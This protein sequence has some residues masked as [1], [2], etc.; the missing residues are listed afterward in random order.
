M[1]MSTALYPGSF[2]PVHNG[3]LG[4]LESIAP[5]FDGVI[6][7]VGHNP[8]KPSGLFTPDERKALLESVTSHLDNV[9]VALF[10]GLVTHAANELGADCLV[11]GLR[12]GSD[13]ATEMQQAAMNQ[14][15]GHIETMFVPGLG[16]AGLVAG[17]YVR[18]I[19]MLGGDVS[20]VVPAAVMSALADKVAAAS[21]SS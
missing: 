1:F 8:D 15:T 9:T 2:D 14:E 19:A 18:Q 3:H 13:L 12:G 11:K 21:G 16:S 4:V 20:S 7:G 6:I 10:S 5:L 17:T